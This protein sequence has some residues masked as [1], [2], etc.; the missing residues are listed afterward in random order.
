MSLI[1]TV[2]RLRHVFGVGGANP[3]R[4]GRWGRGAKGMQGAGNHM[5]K[6]VQGCA[7]RVSILVTKRGPV[8]V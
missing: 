1:G 5:L 2:E 7:V 3:G 6:G 8:K 4:E